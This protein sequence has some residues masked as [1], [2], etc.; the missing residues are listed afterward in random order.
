MSKGNDNT[1][2]YIVIFLVIIGL[3]YSSSQ[4]QDKDGIVTP[5]Q[6]ELLLQ[7]LI[8]VPSSGTLSDCEDWR[9]RKIDDGYD[10][11]GD[12]VY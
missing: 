5:T 12:C 4:E 1:I 7:S 8:S 9:D 6:A 11:V 10:C 2:I 3:L